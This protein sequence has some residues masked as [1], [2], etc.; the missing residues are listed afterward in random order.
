MDLRSVRGRASTV[1]VPDGVRALGLEVTG[2]APYAEV[3]ENP[4]WAGGME[5]I[6]ALFPLRGPVITPRRGEQV[7]S[8]AAFCRAQAST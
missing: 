1:Y 3:D 7:R 5:D 8:C 4:T 6:P 2:I